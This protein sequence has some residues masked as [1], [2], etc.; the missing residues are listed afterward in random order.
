MILTP[1]QM[2]QA[3]ERAFAAGNTAD[4]LMEEVGDLMA[5]AIRR[6]NP[7]PGF[8][9]VF[10]G[11]GNNAG[12]AFVA[13][14][15]LIDAGWQVGLRL[16]Y[17][18]AELGELPAAKLALLREY[19]R[20]QTLKGSEVLYAP[21]LPIIVLDG[22]LGLGGKG[23]L[24]EPVQ[25]LCREI[26]LLRQQRHARVYAMDLPSGLD[27]ETGHAADHCVRADF[28]LTVAYTK[29][30]LL[31]DDATNYVG[32]LAIL[33]IPSLEQ[34]PVDLPEASPDAALSADW[35]A[36]WLPHR[37]FNSHKGDYGR[38]GIVAGSR[39]FPGAARMCAEGALRAGAGLVTLFVTEDVY[40][41]L[42]T[43]CP[44]EVMVRPVTTYLEALD[45]TL[46][47]I[48]IG[49]GLGTAARKPVLDL[50][51]KWAKPMVVDADAIT[52][53]STERSLLEEC[54][55]PRLL[56]PHPGEMSRLM[57]DM[58]RHRDDA[59]RTFT[60][61]YPVTLLLKGA[62]TII[63]EKGQ[64][65]L[66]N[67]TGTPGMATGGM[68]DVL[69]GVTAA[70]AAA[71]GLHLRQAAALGAWLC[72]RA[73]ELALSDYLAPRSEESLLP[74]DLLHYLGA[75]FQELRFQS[76]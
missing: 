53:L 12:D 64:P 8:C 67:T 65:L 26:N 69:T 66:Y 34:R 46:D 29:K 5:Q 41:V 62:R 7:A 3:E 50:I 15:Y 45:N 36:G 72:G 1:Q 63:A 28:T 75:A 47:V 49:P 42:A 18:E 70:L 13:A 61:R 33:P 38:I 30:G 68:G 51:E 2:R 48:A 57:P 19:P 40:P 60:G 22:L 25:G 10:A 56:T 20:I 31:A 74:T 55:G 16:A 4:A 39:R 73:S 24:R 44:P 32:R 37:N 52:L 23:Q 21:G 35:L 9:V 58:P 14:R 11:K 54:A 6:F 43:A 59:A 76:F 17:P 27:A 71:P